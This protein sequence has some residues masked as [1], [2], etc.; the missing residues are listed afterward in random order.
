MNSGQFE[1]K[2]LQDD[3]NFMEHMNITN[4]QQSFVE[5]RSAKRSFE[6]DYCDSQTKKQ[7]LDNEISEF[8]LEN[9]C[10]LNDFEMEIIDNN[11]QPVIE[12]NTEK[13]KIIESNESEISLSLMECDNV[14]NQMILCE[15]VDVDC[16]NENVI[17]VIENVDIS[18][19]SLPCES[20][21]SNKC[22][23]KN[24]STLKKDD[25]NDHHVIEKSET[26]T[27]SANLSLPTVSLEA[28]NVNDHNE[29][30]RDN[31]TG[32]IFSCISQKNNEIVKRDSTRTTSDEYTSVDSPR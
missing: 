29:N 30:K 10:K 9:N 15:L 28:L 21:N 22:N 24:V 32:E 13:S 14:N 5:I 1:D 17:P 3:F 20:T 25:V 26:E 12:N 18:V 4:E 6:H 8:P 2:D 19:Q 31:N 16:N 7:K 23:E 11:I 27:V